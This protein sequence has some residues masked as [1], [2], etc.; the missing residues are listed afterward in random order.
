MGVMGF[1]YQSCNVSV[2]CEI[3]VDIMSF[4]CGSLY[5][6]LDPMITV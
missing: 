3:P 5:Y 1:R 2:N 6:N 4:Q